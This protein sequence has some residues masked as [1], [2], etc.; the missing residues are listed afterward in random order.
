MCR[1]VS[2]RSVSENNQLG[3]FSSLRDSITHSRV[4]PYEDPSED[5]SSSSVYSSE[6]STPDFNFTMPIGKKSTVTCPICFENFDSEKFKPLIL[7][8]CGHT[9]C[10]KCLKHIFKA[11]S[12]IKCPVC[13]KN[14]PTEMSKLP[15]N[16]A[17]LELTENKE[18]YQVC[19]IHK[20]EIVGYCVNDSELLCGACVMEH[21]GHECF[22]LNDPQVVDIANKKKQGIIEEEKRLVSL[23]NAW[24]KAEDDF[25]DL[26]N[27]I[28][29]LKESH[30]LH[31]KQTEN[32]IIENVKAGKKKCIS[33]LQQMRLKEELKD[34]EGVINK[35]LEFLQQE[36]NSNKLKKE[37]YEDIS[38]LEKLLKP[39]I[40]NCPDE[41]KVPS[42]GP[43]YKILLKL[44]AEINYKSSIKNHHIKPA[45]I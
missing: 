16:C 43:W 14:N 27:S 8:K 21:V 11:S 38:V 45:I 2:E 7:P 24:I 15:V 6:R 20:L 18:E 44:K 1:D 19:E 42:L 12:I 33:E 13:R 36:L 32:K 30:I 25:D 17:L 10:A 9:I 35:K 22:T 4:W 39:S 31:L 26:F 29:Q 28:N 40:L 5:W 37:K 23:R 34:I 41:Q 3:L